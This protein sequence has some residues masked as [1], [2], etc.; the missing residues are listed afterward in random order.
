MHLTFLESRSIDSPE[1]IPSIEIRSKNAEKTSI[2]FDDC[3]A[4]EYF[5]V[6][7]NNYQSYLAFYF[8]ALTISIFFADE[9]LTT[10][11]TTIK[12][13]R[14]MFQTSHEQSFEEIFHTFD[15]K[16]IPFAPLIG[17]DH[18]LVGPVRLYFTMTDLYIAPFD[19]SLHELKTVM[20]NPSALKEKSIFCIPYFT[21]KHYGNRGRI[22]L[23]EL[24]KSKY[25]DGELRLKC[26]TS[27]M[28][29]TI[30]L[31]ASPII[32]ERPWVLS[33]AFAN[34]FITDKRRAKLQQSHPPIPFHHDVS[35]GPIIDLSLPFLQKDETPPVEPPL[36]VVKSRSF[37]NTFRK[38]VKHVSPLQRSATFDAA[39]PL[40]S[41]SPTFLPADP[42]PSIELH[43]PEVTLDSYVDLKPSKLAEVPELPEDQDEEDR[44][45]KRMI[46]VGVNSTS[47][48]ASQRFEN[49]FHFVSA[50]ISISPQVRSA[51]IVGNTV[52]LITEGSFD[53]WKNDDD[54]SPSI[55]F[56]E[57]D[58]FPIGQRSFTSPASVLQPFRNQLRG[59]VTVNN[60]GEKRHFALLLLQHFLSPFSNAS[61]SE[62]HLRADQLEVRRFFSYG[63]FET[64]LVSV[65]F[66]SRV[67]PRRPERICS[68][69]MI[70]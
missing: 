63:S 32:E 8:P 2:A 67:P 24:G 57:K 16:L 28:A 9:H 36:P 14:S 19:T 42:L 44:G 59:Q 4:V 70:F 34:Q 39:A 61:R 17:R 47:L 13:L 65:R 6:I 11:E 21:I 30:H 46:D 54:D 58:V 43:E 53:G 20:N 56:A 29:S 3:L 51:I 22:F 40:V 12:H 23:V 37:V 41:P 1:E 69:R 15:A 10:K 7:K 48:S 52:H 27:T 33:S 38:F 55:F 64:F 68:S 49:L 50:I 45:E 60:Y 66:I 62:H 31:F 35:K 18:P 26:S 5:D 25:G